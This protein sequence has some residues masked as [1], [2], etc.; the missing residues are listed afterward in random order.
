[1][2]KDVNLTIDENLLAVAKKHI[3]NLSKFFT[4]CLESWLDYQN[5]DDEQKA[6]ELLKQTAKINDAK[7][8]I[9]LLLEDT[10]YE[11]NA[12][13]KIK[14]KKLSDIWLTIWAPYRRGAKADPR[15]TQEAMEKLGL[16]EEELEDILSDAHYDY[17][18]KYKG[19]EYL[20][21]DWSFVRENYPIEWNIKEVKK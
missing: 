16:D 9:F 4:E 6:A 14:N 8:K 19:Q 15:D 10:Y 20:F 17:T 5:K 3:P 7:M 21:D 18:K 11:E 12:E 1:M 13:E 2:K